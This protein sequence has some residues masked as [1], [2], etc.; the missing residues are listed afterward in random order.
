MT[1]FQ[2]LGPFSLHFLRKADK[3][4]KF[5]LLKMGVG[6]EFGADLLFLEKHSKAKESRRNRNH[7]E[8]GGQRNHL[9]ESTK[10]T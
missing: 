1:E 7:Q 3:K 5:E 9:R 10:M 4:A 2:G 6:S 8:E